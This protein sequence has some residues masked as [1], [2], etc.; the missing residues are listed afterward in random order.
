MLA[1]LGVLMGVLL[2]LNGCAS[3]QYYRNTSQVIKGQP[4]KLTNVNSLAKEFS[5]SDRVLK[6]RLNL[7]NSFY[8]IGRGGVFKYLFEERESC[9]VEGNQAVGPM[10]LNADRP[11]N[12]FVQVNSTA[13]VKERERPESASK[14]TTGPEGKDAG[15]KKSAPTEIKVTVSV[16][17][18][19]KSSVNKK[20]ESP[21]ELSV[22]STI[23][24]NSRLH[25][26]EPADR[27]EQVVSLI[28]PVPDGVDILG[29]SDPFEKTLVQFGTEDTEVGTSLEL[30][31]GVN[32]GN[33]F[34]ATPSVSRKISRKLA[35]QFATKNVQ[36]SELRNVLLVFLDGGPQGADIAGQAT[37]G[38]NVALSPSLCHDV[39]KKIPIVDPD[40]PGNIE[41][42]GKEPSCYIPGILAI[43]ASIAVVR[44]VKHG[45]KTV[46]EDDDVIAQQVFQNASIFELWRNPE[47]LFALEGEEGKLLEEGHGSPIVFANYDDAN[48]YRSRMNMPARVCEV[49][50]VVRRYDPGRCK[51]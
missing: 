13:A 50:N 3:G 10:Y 47:R 6:T 9:D 49:S 35:R 11:V 8:S 44:R 2:I 37:T 40:K 14:E 4:F 38:I 25:T 24:I 43:H 48:L 21:S 28:A 33:L 16:D 46:K 34:K 23:N 7:L 51:L 1:R 18:G 30:P 26:L 42:E 27:I 39:V 5:V 12:A 32:E 31:L 15:R 29:L 22:T 41:F 45:F 17:D 20:S 19:S 36:V